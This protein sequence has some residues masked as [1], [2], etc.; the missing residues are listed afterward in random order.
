MGGGLF[1]SVL[2]CVNDK[3]TSNINKSKQMMLVLLYIAIQ[4]QTDYLI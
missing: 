4:D 3:K 2:D 1:C